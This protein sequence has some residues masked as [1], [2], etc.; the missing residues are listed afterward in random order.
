MEAKNVSYKKKSVYVWM[1][2]SCKHG[3]TDILAWFLQ[4]KVNFGEV[5]D[6]CISFQRKGHL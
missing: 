3:Y 2:S 4:K 1:A 5:F 6:C